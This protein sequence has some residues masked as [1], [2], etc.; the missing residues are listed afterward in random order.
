MYGSVYRNLQTRKIAKNR[1]S[2]R[3]FHYNR[4]LNTNGHLLLS[5]TSASI[6]VA[7]E[8]CRKNGL[9]QKVLG[10][11]SSAR[12]M[13]T[14]SVASRC[15]QEPV[16]VAQTSAPKS[17]SPSGYD[18]AAKCYNPKDSMAYHC[19]GDHMVGGTE[20][21]RYIPNNVRQVRK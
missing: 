3:V 12:N 20:M 18:F 14:P 4:N 8:K 17:S 1:M 21:A 16:A 11:R 2:F 15:S 10:A 19:E 9:L 6:R 7:C 5:I 13:S